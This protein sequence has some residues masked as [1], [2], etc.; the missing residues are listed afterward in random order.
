MTR[1]L[2]STLPAAALLAWAA[3]ASAQESGSDAT[4]DALDLPD[5]IAGSEA[6]ASAARTIVEAGADKVLLADLIGSE[7]AGPSGEALGTVED[8]AAIP[9]GRLIA[10]LVSL[11]DGTMVAL[12]YQA[13]KLDAAGE[14]AR[15]T[16]DLTAEELRALPELRELADALGG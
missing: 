9:G 1:P 8:L 14:T 4:P 6:V 13:L 15:A 12:P 11:D 7:V 16:L 3:A 2:F 5:E 10:A